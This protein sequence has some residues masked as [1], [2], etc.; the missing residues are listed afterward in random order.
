[1]IRVL[2]LGN[3]LMSDGGFGAA[4]I[5]AFEAEY[6]VGPEV[7]I[8]DVGT[9]GLD[10]TPWLAD[11]E[12]VIIIDTV[13]TGQAPGT[14]RLYDKQELLR[15]SPSVGVGT[16]D[17][18]VGEALMRLDFAERGPREVA[19][20]GIVPARTGVGLE[21]SPVVGSMVSAGVELL[22]RMLRHFGA[23]MTRRENP[24]RQPSW[25]NVPATAILH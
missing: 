9:L 6:T 10:L 4:V 24:M 19:F 3:A 13:N 18:R 17:P 14:L 5:R 16:H 20:V 23:P 7:Q 22:E 8:V 15:R 21:L 1:M 11:A 2:G 12:R 25:F